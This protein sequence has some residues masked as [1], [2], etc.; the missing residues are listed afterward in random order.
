MVA[1]KLCQEAAVR[2]LAMFQ[3]EPIYDDEQLCRLLDDTRRL[4]EITRR[5]ACGK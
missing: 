3:H 4:E 2:R 5:C 1:I